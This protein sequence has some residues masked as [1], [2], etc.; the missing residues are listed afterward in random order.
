M[1]NLEADDLVKWFLNH[2]LR[3]KSNIQDWIDAHRHFYSDSRYH[4][5]HRTDHTKNKKVL[6]MKWADYLYWTVKYVLIGTVIAVLKL[7]FWDEY[8]DETEHSIWRPTNQVGDVHG[9]NQT[10]CPLISFQGHASDFL[11]WYRCAKLE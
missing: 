10:K 7:P 11:W 4:W 6:R 8:M 2:Y 1:L 5:E 9:K 3:I